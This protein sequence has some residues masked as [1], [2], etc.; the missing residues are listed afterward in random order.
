MA[1]CCEHGNEH[2][3]IIQI[4][5]FI[6][7]SAFFEQLRSYLVSQERLCPLDLFVELRIKTPRQGELLLPP[8]LRSNN[9]Q[10]ILQIAGQIRSQNKQPYFP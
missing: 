5:S 2:F 6:Y 3:K 4:L 8:D 1:G 7:C 10:F 9:P